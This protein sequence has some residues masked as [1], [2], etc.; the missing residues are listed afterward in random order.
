LTKHN[1]SEIGFYL[2]LQVKPTQLGPID[3]A[4]PYL[5][6]PVSVP[7]LGI[8][9]QD[10]TIHQ[11][12]LRQFLNFVNLKLRCI[13]FCTSDVS[14]IEIIGEKQYSLWCQPKKNRISTQTTLEGFVVS[15]FLLR[16]RGSRWERWPNWVG[17]LDDPAE[18]CGPTSVRWWD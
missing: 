8:K 3:R 7:K 11:W 1:V 18:T 13:R 16:S 15:L 9:S 2:R 4:S 5:R 17:W 14:R 6:T 10:N 12:E